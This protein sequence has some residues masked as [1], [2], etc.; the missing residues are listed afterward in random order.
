MQNNVVAFPYQGS[1]PVH[2]Q[3]VHPQTV[4]GQGQEQYLPA[5]P[6]VAMQVDR[7]A[8]RVPWYAWFGVGLYLMYRLLR[9]H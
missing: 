2:P 9:R 5:F 7:H 4:Q 3:T 8:R 6:A 1:G